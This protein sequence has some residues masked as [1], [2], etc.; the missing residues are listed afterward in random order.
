MDREIKFGLTIVARDATTAATN[1]VR[2]G[3]KAVGDEAAKADDKGQFTRTREGLRSISGQLESAR[4]LYLGYQAAVQAARGVGDITNRAD[5]YAGYTARLRLATA[6]QTGFNQA[7]ADVTAI[8]NQTQAPVEAVASLYTKLN[9]SLKE[10]GKTQADTRDISE[11][12]AL[13]LKVSGANASESGAA[14]LQLSQAFASGV[15]RG[16]EFNSVNE[17]APRLMKALADGLGVPVGRLREMAEQGELTAEVMANVLPKA[18]AELRLE[19]EQ[20]P[21]TISGATQQ[22]SD[23]Y[24]RYIG[25]AGQATGLSSGLAAAIQILAKHFDVLG[26]AVIA[27][28]LGAMVAGIA[29]TITVVVGLTRAAGVATVSLGGLRIAMAALSAT[30][31]GAFLTLAA[32]LGAILFATNRLKDASEESAQA[33]VA[34]AQAVIDKRKELEVRL[35]ALIKRRQ[36][37]ESQLATATK[38]AAEEASK[39]AIKAQKDTLSESKKAVEEE[40]RDAERLRDALTKA[41]DDAGEQAKKYRQEATDLRQKGKE[42]GTSDEQSA[43]D[44]RLNRLKAENAELAEQQRIEAVNKSLR[45]ADLANLQAQ[46]AMWNGN[47]EAAQRYQEEAA[48]AAARAKDLAGGIEG[49]TNQEA[50]YAE[51]AKQARAALETQAGIKDRMAAKAEQEQAGI[52]ER[53]QA[54]AQR[55]GDLQTQL[56][57]VEAKIK[58]LEAPK[59]IK[60]AFDQTK[61]DEAKNAIA[62]IRAELDDLPASKTVSV[63]VQR[64]GDQGGAAAI[65]GKA[66]G[67]EIAGNGPKGRDSVLMYGA[68]GE[69]VLTAAEVDAAGGHGAIYALRA[70]LR[71]GWRPEGYAQG[72]AVMRAVSA[73]L[74]S[75]AGRPLFQGGATHNLNLTLPDGLGTYRMQAAPDVMASLGGAVRLMR[76][77]TGRRTGGRN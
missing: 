48:A 67:G 1:G 12:V 44:R 29:G 6:S 10:L 5:A 55:L 52:G 77:R 61:L 58:A 73:G 70:A 19:A 11:V 60:V 41:W 26:D 50:A 66:S 33:E 23:A 46:E 68:P 62:A 39:A 27:L 7:L 18:L 75:G 76:L 72:G 32:T 40:I 59:E 54:N 21:A 43:E 49:A 69:H 74:S 14:I 8:S 25:E 47:T 45:E 38:V 35:E 17:N 30:P 28:G 2:T 22:L 4:R 63:T 16:D 64:T 65:P 20:I 31:L 34:A 71:S 57:D 42:Q 37:L 9:G 51:A 3:L 36:D 56:A 53:Q 15:L 24:T 13:S